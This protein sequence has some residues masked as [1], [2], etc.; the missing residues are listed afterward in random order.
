MSAAVWAPAWAEASG[1][2]WRCLRQQRRKKESKERH[3]AKRPQRSKVQRARGPIPGKKGSG[4]QEGRRRR[5]GTPKPRGKRKTNDERG[6]KTHPQPPTRHLSPTPAPPPQP[7]QRYEARGRTHT[8]TEEGLQRSQKSDNR[9]G[10]QGRKPSKAERLQKAEPGART[11]RHPAYGPSGE[12]ARKPTNKAEPPLKR[13]FRAKPPNKT[14]A[15][16]PPLKS[17]R[18]RYGALRNRPGRDRKPNPKPRP[19][20]N[21]VMGHVC[22]GSLKKTPTNLTHH[23]R[24]RK[25]EKPNTNTRPKRFLTRRWGSGSTADLVRSPSSSWTTVLPDPLSPRGARSC[26]SVA[27]GRAVAATTAKPPSEAKKATATPERDQRGWLLKPLPGRQAAPRSDPKPGRA[28]QGPNHEK[29]QGRSKANPNSRPD[30]RHPN[31]ETHRNPRTGPPTQR[32]AR[33]RCPGQ[34]TKRTR[35]QGEPEKENPPQG[36]RKTGRGPAS[37]APENGRVRFGS[38]NRGGTKGAHRTKAEPGVRSSRE[39]W[40]EEGATADDRPR[41]RE[42]RKNKTK[43]YTTRVTPV[44]PQPAALAQPDE[45]RICAELLRGVT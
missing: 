35:P 17:N 24:N 44:S 5:G 30:T 39:G 41:T 9:K 37:R 7:L 40:G 38:E 8:K 15:T 22:W 14:K 13:P 11:P 18:P 23:G 32:H 27:R 33:A 29:P 26:R 1:Q 42:T 45:F 10:S 31:T 21:H 19:K 43:L 28:R 2:L 36:R 16:P 34:E 12:R 4:K 6:A 25:S 20:E 3:R